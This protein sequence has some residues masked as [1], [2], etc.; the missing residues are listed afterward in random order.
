MDFTWIH[1]PTRLPKPPQ[2]HVYTKDRPKDQ[3]DSHPEEA[4]PKEGHLGSADPWIGR[5]DLGSANPG[6]P[7]GACP[8]VL[9]AIPKVFHSSLRRCSGL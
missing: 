9:E 3:Q 4:H 7:R 2:E 6:P 1:G 5:T 8:L